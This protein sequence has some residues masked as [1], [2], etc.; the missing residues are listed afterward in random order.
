ME[1]T[2]EIENFLKNEIEKADKEFLEK[3]KNA[4]DKKDKKELEKSYGEKLK[5]T[6]EKYEEKCKK[7][8]ERQK[9]ITMRQ[10]NKLP[11]KKQEK[12]KR[13]KVKKL[14]L[15][16]SWKENL[17]LKLDLIKFRLKI[18]TR[19]FFRRIM[20]SF[21]AISYLKIKFKVKR[22]FSSVKKTMAEGF[23]KT[24]AKISVLLKDLVVASKNIFLKIYPKIKK[25]FLL[26]IKF[27][28]KLIGKI[29]K[30][31]TGDGK[32]EKTE[33]EK[34]IEKILSKKTEKE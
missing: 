16:L 8:L 24:K 1:E 6:R 7:Y 19:N 11:K 12:I 27:I 33:E 30:K 31:K 28:I 32:K 22:V 21:L 14:R 34:L 26:I 4:K 2:E 15:E 23:S 3:L 18:K 25:F 13:F 10:K 5:Q 17:S 9:K 29:K 20:P